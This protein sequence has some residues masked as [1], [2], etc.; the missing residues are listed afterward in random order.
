MTAKSVNLPKFKMVAYVTSVPA[1]LIP[2]SDDETYMLNNEGHALTKY[3]NG[4]TN[5]AMNMVCDRLQER[6]N[7]HVNRHNSV[8]NQM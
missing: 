4:S 2:A 1:C 8:N 5:S 6:C 3:D 7:G